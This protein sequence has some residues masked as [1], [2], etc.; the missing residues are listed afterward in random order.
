MDR[1]R[2]YA[3]LR[4]RDSGVFGTSL[5][6]QQ[7]NALEAM[8]DEGQRRGTPLRHL[9][10]ILASA[11]HEVGSSLQPI[12]ENLN[13]TAERIR[14][15]WPTRFA[16]VS[17]AQ[18]YARNPQKLANRVYGGRLG[19]GNEASG[20]GWRFRGRGYIQITGRVN[21]RKFGIETTPD[22]ALEPQTAIRVMFDGMT[23]GA[24]TGKRL[25][26]YLDGPADYVSARAIVNGDV[27]ANG[28]KIA[29]YAKAFETALNEA[30]YTTTAA[31]PA[32]AK[33]APMPQPVQPPTAPPAPLPGADDRNRFLAFLIDIFAG[34]FAFLGFKRKDR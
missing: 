33:P 32:P 29:G 34:L 27:K 1:S 16:S 5:S 8:L 19:N 6:Q 13:Y 15:V 10:Y 17:A 18:P 31:P 20:D 28:G 25:S 4:R 9:A 26:S 30:G 12:S 21:Y 23:T 7:V 22:K 11:Y 3:A 14:Q 2:F 24:F